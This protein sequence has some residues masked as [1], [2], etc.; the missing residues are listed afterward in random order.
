MKFNADN[1]ITPRT[2]EKAIK[3]GI[4]VWAEAG[5]LTREVAGQDEEQYEFASMISEL[6]RQMENAARN[7]EFERAAKL[8]DR[9][10][11]LN[12]QAKGR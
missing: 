6:E 11:A 9:L 7:L 3:A 8:R 12:A 5:D 10:A 2:I 1:G 4:E